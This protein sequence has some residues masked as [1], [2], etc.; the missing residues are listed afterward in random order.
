M[1]ELNASLRIFLF[2][3]HSRGIKTADYVR[4]CHTLESLRKSRMRL[5]ILFALVVRG[6]YSTLLVMLQSKRIIVPHAAF[7]QALYWAIKVQTH[8]SSTLPS[9]VRGRSCPICAIKCY[10]DCTFVKNILWY[11]YEQPNSFR[12]TSC[13]K[14]IPRLSVR[15]FAITPES[16]QFRGLDNRWAAAKK[17]SSS[18][19]VWRSK[20]TFIPPQFFFWNLNFSATLFVLLRSVP[21]LWRFLRCQKKLRQNV[22]CRNFFYL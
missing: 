6:C 21:H 9:Q 3:F 8:R 14:K 15:L 4:I 17:F 7:T 20:C 11:A 10:W 13:I 22:T 2:N 12:D 19:A 5:F 16:P 1:S 18:W